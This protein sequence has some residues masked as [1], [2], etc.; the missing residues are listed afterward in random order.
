MKTHTIGVWAKKYVE[1]L[2]RIRYVTIGDNVTESVDGTT[3]EDCLREYRAT[4]F[5][6]ADHK[7]ALLDRLNPD[8]ARRQRGDLLLGRLNGEAIQIRPPSH[9]AFRH[10]DRAEHGIVKLLRD[11]NV[12]RTDKNM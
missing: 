2:C 12:V 9:L 8:V 5:T 10:A 6:G 1:T 7:A 3:C 4:E 11:S